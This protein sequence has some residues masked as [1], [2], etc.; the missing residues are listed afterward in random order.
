M[1]T[2]T[3]NFSYHIRVG[4]SIVCKIERINHGISKQTQQVLSSK[5]DVMNHQGFGPET[6]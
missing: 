2:F 3:S 5:I 4:A 6:I 1:I